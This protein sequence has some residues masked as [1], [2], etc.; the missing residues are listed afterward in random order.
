MTPKSPARPRST[1]GTLPSGGRFGG[2]EFTIFLPRTSSGQ[3]A[4][5][6]ERL[7]AAVPHLA[8]PAASPGSPAPAG[9]TV[10]IGVVATSRATGSLLDSLATADRALYRAKASGQNRVCLIS[11]DTP[12]SEPASLTGQP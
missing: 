8:I 9:I 6:A 4:R 1:A 12:T 3:A 11:D 2:E 7:R 5:I 10:S